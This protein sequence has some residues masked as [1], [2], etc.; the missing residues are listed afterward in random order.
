MYAGRIDE[1]V[2]GEIGASLAVGP[3]LLVADELDSMLDINRKGAD[4][5]GCVGQRLW[6]PCA[7]ARRPDPTGAA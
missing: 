5:E 7:R 3:E 6:L 2:T 4:S 1:G